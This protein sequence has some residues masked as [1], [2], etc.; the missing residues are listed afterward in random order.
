MPDIEDQ[1][2]HRLFLVFQA[3]SD[4]TS[5]HV[6]ADSTSLHVVADGTTLPVMRRAGLAVSQLFNSNE[7]PQPSS[8]AT[9]TIARNPSLNGIPRNILAFRTITKLL[10]L[11]QPERAFQ[12]VT[13]PKSADNKRHLE[14]KLINALATVGVIN[15]EVVAVVN[16][17]DSGMPDSDS[18]KLGVIVSVEPMP[19]PPSKPLAANFWRLLFSKNYRPDDPQTNLTGQPVIKSAE[20]LAAIELVDKQTIQEYAEEYR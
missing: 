20:D 17:S 12:A 3:V 5:F 19:I 18:N 13:Q 11:I 1:I 2:P 15:H 8:D 10:S 7:P 6:M 14:L 9:A 16:R 4:S